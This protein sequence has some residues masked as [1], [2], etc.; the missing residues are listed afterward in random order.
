MKLS[1]SENKYEKKENTE[2]SK[3]LT[4]TKLDSAS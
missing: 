1:I 3:T 4:A 2:V